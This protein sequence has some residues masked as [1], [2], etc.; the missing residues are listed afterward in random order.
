MDAYIDQNGQAR[1]ERRLNSK[2]RVLFPEARA[3]LHAR[4]HAH[5]DWAGTSE[6]YVALRLV[7]QR[8]PELTATEVRVLVTAIGRALFPQGHI[9]KLTS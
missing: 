2:L 6:D 4:F 3:W 5:D 8:Y 9:D 1:T 7:H